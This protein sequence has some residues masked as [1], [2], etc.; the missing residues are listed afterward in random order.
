MRIHFLLAVLVLAGC[1]SPQVIKEEEVPTPSAAS[2]ETREQQVSIDLDALERSL[3]LARPLQEL[4]YREASFN[5]CSVGYGYSSS[6]DCRKMVMASI[7]FRLQ[8]RDSEGTISTALGAQD[9]VAIGGQRVRW[10][11]QKQDD[12]VTT[13]GEGYMNLHAVFAKSPKNDWLRVA[14]GV[15]FLNIRANSISRVVT[16]RPWCHAD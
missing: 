14:V 8:C 10:T 5:T 13:D 15:Q 1:A 6:K 4:G 11:L 3:N 12:V 16:P 9:L 7:N 2:L